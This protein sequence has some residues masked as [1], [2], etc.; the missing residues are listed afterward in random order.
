M[1]TNEVDLKIFMNLR[2]LKDIKRCNNFPVVNQEDVAQHS[3]YVTL[4]AMFIANEY[5]AWAFENNMKYHPLDADNTYKVA[6]VNVI[7][8]QA[9]AHDLEESF[10]SDIPW[11][12]K[13]MKEVHTV[14]T[15][16][17]NQRIDSIFENSKNMK[18]YRNMNKFCKHGFEGRF[19][20]LADMLEL[21]IYCWEE[22]AKGNYFLQPMLDK[23]IN[24]LQSMDEYGTMLKASSLFK[25]L[26]E[27]IKSDSIK[28]ETLLDIN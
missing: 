21:A 11:N 8:E 7:I 26:M 3:F 18:L 9:L 17:I 19:V 5:N 4:L 1:E 20:E 27:L 14:L 16:A 25:S 6:R 24:L 28:A 13:H 22:K 23:C 2:R 15:E 10:T 12:I